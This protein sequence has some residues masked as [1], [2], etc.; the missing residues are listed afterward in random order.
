MIVYNKTCL[1][2]TEDLVAE[3]VDLVVSS[4]PYKITDGFSYELI[5]GLSY[6]LVRAMK[7][8]TLAF[9][10]FGHLTGHKDR[11]FKMLDILTT[12]RSNG[13]LNHVDTI[14]WVK[15]SQYTGGHYTP[16]NSPYMLNNMFE[17]IFMLSKGKTEIDRLS[18]GIPYRDKSNIKRWGKQDLRCAGNVWYISYPTI[19]NKIEKPHKDRFPEE[20]PRRCIKLSGIEKGSIVLD[21]FMGSGTT[22]KVADQMS[23][24]S[25]GYETNPVYFGGYC[26]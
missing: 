18:I 9:I 8:N 5:E 12:P 4:P 1:L 3:S 6:Q 2:M 22:G 25:I 16:I 14:I 23:M 11:P 24:K 26:E 15:S 17:Y 13:K 19:Q 21:P 20:L 7:Q 10:N